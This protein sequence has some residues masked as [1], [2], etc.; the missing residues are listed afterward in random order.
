MIAKLTFLIDAHVFGPRF[1]TEDDAVGTNC[2]VDALEMNGVRVIEGCQWTVH[3]S[4]DFHN[5][6]GTE[7]ARLIEFDF[8]WC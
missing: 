7:Y 3:L 5:Q 4:I 6:R 1:T 8:G 2:L